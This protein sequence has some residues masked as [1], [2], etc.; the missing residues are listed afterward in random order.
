MSRLANEVRVHLEKA[1][2]SALLAVETY[3]RPGARFRSGG[4]IVLMCIAWTALLHA[5][6]FKRKI[7]PFYRKKSHRGHFEIVDGDRK[8]WELQT[9]LREYFG[10]SI[11]PQRKNVEFFIG[12]RNKIEHRSMPA[13]DLR[14]FGECQALLFNFE[15]LLVSEFGEKYALNESLTLALQFSCIRNEDQDAA[16]RKLHKPLAKSVALY[17][18]TFRSALGTEILSDPRFSYKLFLIPKPANHAGS[19]DSAVEFVK[20]D[21]SKPEEMNRYDKIVTLIKPTALAVPT[22]EKATSSSAGLPTKIRI[23][24]SEAAISAIK[25]DYDQ[26][27]P[28][29]Q[30][31]LLSIVNQRLPELGRINTHDLLAIRRTHEI[32]TNPNFYHK[33]L[34]GPAQYSEAFADWLVESYTKDADFFRDARVAYYEIT[35]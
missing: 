19:A 5:V 3:N 31:D 18:E 23:V 7:K 17:V 13:L 8:G 2:D 9:C 34:F 30:K 33:G 1:R 6:F 16:M 10:P 21:P 15:D 35:H 11:Q 29:R 28:F 25:I 4:F 27:H 32:S 26:S 22:G 14:I 20:F 24:N 12:L